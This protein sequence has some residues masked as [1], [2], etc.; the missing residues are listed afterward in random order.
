MVVDENH[1]WEFWAQC[2]KLPP[3]DYIFVSGS[4]YNIYKQ[5][6]HRGYIARRCFRRNGKQRINW[7]ITK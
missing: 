5:L 6:V 1:L 3:P 2:G 7:G 4:T